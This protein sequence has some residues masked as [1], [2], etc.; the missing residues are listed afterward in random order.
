MNLASLS[1]TRLA[2]GPGSAV[3]SF[4]SFVSV[5]AIISSSSGKW[6]A[7]NVDEL[8][9]GRLYAYTN[10]QC[11]P[12][13]ERGCLVYAEEVGTQLGWGEIAGEPIV[14]RVFHLRFQRTLPSFESSMSI[15]RTASSLRMRSDSAKSRRWRAAWRSATSLSISASLGP[16]SAAPQPSARNFSASLSS[17]T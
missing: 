8:P 13:Q 17:I 10:T 1:T 11:A 6:S 4:G 7:V 15:P 16:L 5:V 3:T 12:C 14:L 9:Q 2:L